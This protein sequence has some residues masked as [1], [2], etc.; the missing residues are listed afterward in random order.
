MVTTKIVIEK[1]NS[2]MAT[3]TAEEAEFA[4]APEVAALRSRA[5]VISIRAA[6]AD[7][8]E[9]EIAPAEQNLM[10]GDIQQAA[11]TETTDPEKVTEPVEETE[12][13]EEIELVEQTEP[14]EATESIEEL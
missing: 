7:E 5:P 9:T 10:E 12:Q 4:E 2:M 14:G 11:S 1:M 13:V 3:T 6:V 8:P